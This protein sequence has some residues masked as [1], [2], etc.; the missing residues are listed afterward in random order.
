M[1]E[2]ILLCD[3]TLRDGEQAPGIALNFPEKEVIARALVDAK[4]DE[5]EVGVPAVG[6]DEAASIKQLVSLHLPVRLITWNRAVSSDLEASFRTGVEG[7]AISIPVSDQQ[8]V[9]KLK[10][11]RSWVIEK[12]GESIVQAKKEVN[13]ICL[14]LED[15][16]RADKDFLLPICLEAEKLGVSRVRLADTL[17][18]MN[19]M[20]VYSRFGNLPESV[21]IPLEFHAHNDLGMATANAITAIQSGFR[22]VS[23]TVGGLGERAGNACLEEV[24]VALKY[25]LKKNIRFDHYRLNAVCLVVSLATHRQIQPNKPIVGRDVY[26]HTS[27]LHLDGIYKDIANYESFPPESV[28]RKHSTV[29]GKYSGRKAIIRLLESKG[30]TITNQEMSELMV[31][32]RRQSAILKRPLQEQDILGLVAHAPLS[33]LLM[34]TSHN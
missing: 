30:I 27:S 8:I 32:I 20:E 33:A 19:P 31:K 28:S 15:A 2:N 18:I 23:V 10:R 5:L 24:V 14:G 25:A 6:P 13:Y 4:I 7:V 22:A 34:N 9:R 21:N 17:G 26:T 3:T 11:S 16:S 12:I 29:L 1:E